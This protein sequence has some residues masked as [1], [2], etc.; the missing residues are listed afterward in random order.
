M[1]EL[2]V[3]FIVGLNIFRKLVGD[4][5]WTDKIVKHQQ[6]LQLARRKRRANLI[7]SAECL[8]SIGLGALAATLGIVLGADLGQKRHNDVESYFELN[9]RLEVA[10]IFLCF[11]LFVFCIVYTYKT[12][13]S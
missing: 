11:F 9:E 10:G 3:Q 4:T 1:A 8:F 7:K 6:Q 12:C 13:R 2:L 5:F